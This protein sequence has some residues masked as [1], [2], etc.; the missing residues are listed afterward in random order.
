MSFR[1]C[2]IRGMPET[3]AIITKDYLYGRLR[4]NKITCFDIDNQWIIFFQTSCNNLIT[5]KRISNKIISS[6]VWKYCTYVQQL[7]WYVFQRTTRKVSENIL[8]DAIQELVDQCNDVFEAKTDVLTAYQMN[9]LRTVTDGNHTGLSSAK[10][11]RD[12]HLGSSANVNI[13]K[14]SLLDKDLIVIED[15]KIFLSDPIMGLWLQRE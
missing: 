4:T 7:S 2:L 6:M 10:I 3:R 14:K 9:Y 8:A 11:I 12:Y 13:I 1:R 15:K 5:N